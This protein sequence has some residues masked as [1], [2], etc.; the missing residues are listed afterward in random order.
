MQRGHVILRV[1]QSRPRTPCTLAAQHNAS[2][3]RRAGGQ[4][5]DASTPETR[6]KTMARVCIFFWCDNKTSGGLQESLK[7]N[8]GL[9]AQKSSSATAGMACS[10]LY[11]EIVHLLFQDIRLRQRAAV[12]LRQGSLRA[13][14][15]PRLTLPGRQP[16][17]PASLAWSTG[18]VSYKSSNSA[19]NTTPS[20]TAK[21]RQIT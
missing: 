14:V 17:R 16:S 2:P 21:T 6:P 12:L 10:R 1:V 13:D 5:H 11:N 8:C 3:L 19:R 9:T 4:T 20:W 15:L 18:S 7:K